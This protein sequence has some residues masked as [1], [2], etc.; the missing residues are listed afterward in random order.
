MFQSGAFQSVAFQT[1]WAVATPDTDTVGDSRSHYQ[2]F[3]DAERQ[4]EK[5]RKEKT[6]AQ[7]L[8]SVISEYERRKSITDESLLIAEESERARLLAAQNELITEINRLLI[9]KAEMMARIKRSEELLILML[10]M[11]RKRF[12]VLT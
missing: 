10:A 4:R 7:K 2:R 6:E 5:L 1:V 12:R 9:V 8:Q 11:R 3:Q